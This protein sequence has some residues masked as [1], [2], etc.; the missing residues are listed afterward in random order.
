MN[1][2]NIKLWTDQL[3]RLISI[4]EITSISDDDLNTYISDLES[5]PLFPNLSEEEKN[6]VTFNIKS[7]IETSFSLE[8][9]VLVNPDVVRWLGDKRTTFDWSY[10]KAYKEFL[11]TQGRPL[12][13][14]NENSEIIDNILDLSGDPK[15]PGKWSRKGLV[16]GNVQSGKT[17]NFIGLLNKAADV[18][19]K[20]IIV[21]GG[22]QNELREQTQI[23]IDEGFVGRVPRRHVRNNQISSDMR[24]K[25]GVGLYRDDTKSPISV[26]TI[27]GDFN[28]AAANT[29]N[30]NLEDHEDTPVIFCIKKFT[31]TLRN[32][33]E[34]IV[35]THALGDDGQLESPLLFID[36]ES[37]YATV[38]TAYNR[39]DVTAVNAEIREILT[40][41]KKSTYVGYSATPFS[42][43]F[44]DPEEYDDALQD[45]LFPKD[46]MI[47]IPV[48][49]AYCGQ[50]F[51]FSSA[52]ENNENE[53]AEGENNIS[54]TIEISDNEDLIDFSGHKKNT[55]VRN[56]SRS[57]EDAICCFVLNMSIKKCRENVSEKHDSMLINV[58]YINILQEEVKKKVLKFKN[59]LLEAID[60]NHALGPS[61]ALQSSLISRL[62]NNYETYYSIEESWEEI[63]ENIEWAINK[64]EVRIVSGAANGD[65]AL[66]YSDHPNGLAV[67]AIGGHK[68]SRGLTLEGLSISYFTRNARAYD[69]LMQMCRWFGYKEGYKD[70]CK[71][72]MPRTS[73]EWYSFIKGAID[74]LYSEL[75]K[76]VKQNRTPSEFGLK[77]RN[78]PGSLIVS[79]KNK[80]AVGA[81]EYVSFDLW[82]QRIPR[83]SFFNDE[84]KNDANLEYCKEFLQSLSE[85]HE[86]SQWEENE[87]DETKIYHEVPFEKVID[88]INNMHLN[89]GVNVENIHVIKSIK[90]LEKADAPKFKVCL[91]TAARQAPQWW[92][93][94]IPNNDGLVS[95]YLMDGVNVVPGLR[96][97]SLKNNLI[98][99]KVR[100]LGDSN[101]E[102]KFLPPAERQQVQENC[103]R[104]RA[105]NS[106]YIRAD[107][108]DFPGLSIHLFNLGI[109][110]PGDAQASA[111]DGPQVLQSARYAFPGKPSIGYSVSFPLKESMRGLSEEGFI[112]MNKASTHQY[113][114]NAIYTKNQ[115][116]L[117]DDNEENFDEDDSE[118][119]T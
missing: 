96:S 65:P 115:L 5:S 41:F 101:A 10:W 46:F 107:S 106:D 77:V 32:L 40:K 23:R 100:D 59:D 36:D 75:D 20:I 44:I 114:V 33:K 81:N 104:N 35:E 13:L 109:L 39:D 29:N 34:W 103:L 3:I 26:T 69:T 83:F 91:F 55:E 1:Q 112:E 98:Q 17:Q 74:D 7:S 9:N 95:S 61:E 63:F 21:L 92:S 85:T 50:D 53:L 119:A 94:R 6:R 62:K 25:F 27:D 48:P 37:D 67:I 19:Y 64:I 31:P 38:N 110:S 57:L 43:I 73:I 28:K 116:N 24:N 2:Q 80:I 8:G 54:P 89:D 56:L 12:G 105:I 97:T 14:I 45:D 90:A 68:L 111:E 11:I 49:E 82:G 117:F 72:F 78:H 58:T 70:I 88:F 15:T 87:G 51:F 66:N 113:V 108:R 30:F 18:G 60:S 84:A 86:T 4:N 102:R 52:E 71:V 79:A 22:H 93:Q 42:N 47:R 118:E 76:M 99:A 16:M